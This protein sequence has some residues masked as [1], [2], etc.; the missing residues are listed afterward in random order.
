M[1]YIIINVL[2][3]YCVELKKLEEHKIHELPE[4][5]RTTDD[6]DRPLLND[7]RF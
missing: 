5:K 6:S 3:Q 2:I 4:A 7:N 1:C